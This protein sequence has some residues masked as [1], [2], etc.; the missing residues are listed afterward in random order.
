MAGL[1]TY[2]KYVFHTRCSCL[3]L[4]GGP[5][6]S[7]RIFTR[8]TCPGYVWRMVPELPLLRSSSNSVSSSSS[9]V[10]FIHGAGGSGDLALLACSN[11]R[12]VLT[13][14]RLF[15]ATNDVRKTKCSPAMPAM[16]ERHSHNT[17]DADQYTHINHCWCRLQ[18]QGNHGGPV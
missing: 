6:V 10:H 16:V 18:R 15:F 2:I 14:C 8:A 1:K 17:R 7:L 5:V 12:R 4:A 9:V 11:K 3:S 13:C